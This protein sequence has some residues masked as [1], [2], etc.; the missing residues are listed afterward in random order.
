VFIYQ[1]PEPPRLKRRAVGS[2]NASHNDLI[3][4]EIWQACL[5]PNPKSLERINEIISKPKI[6]FAALKYELISDPGLA[7]YYLKRI[8]HLSESNILPIDPLDY[9]KTISLNELDKLFNISPQQI[10]S[11]K[12]SSSSSGQLLRLQHSF[13]ATKAA[14]NISRQLNVPAGI[15][16]ALSHVSQAAINLL[17]FKYPSQFQRALLNKRRY[18]T[19]IEETLSTLTG[20]NLNTINLKIL[21]L[22]GLPIQ[23]QKEIELSQKNKIFDP[24][25][26][27][28]PITLVGMGDLL[29]RAN[30][31]E[32]FPEAL[33]QWHQIEERMEKLGLE[34]PRNEIE[35]E[36][37][38]F[39]NELGVNS[40]PYKSSLFN[41]EAVEEHSN[42]TKV[43]VNKYVVKLPE[44]LNQDFLQVYRHI[45]KHEF[46]QTALK[47][48]VEKLAP[49]LKIES[50][51]LYLLRS[52]NSVLSA[53]LNFGRIKRKRTNLQ[54]ESADPIAQSLFASSP[55]I[56]DQGDGIVLSCCALQKSNKQG[57]IL[58]EF[59]QTEFE[60]IATFAPNL[61]QALTQTL[62]DIIGQ[63][64]E[65]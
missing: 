21:K 56:Q 16:F 54:I 29:A 19:P 24:T 3:F 65:Q 58:L 49:K 52:D 32:H 28:N 7:L 62:V 42:V 64:S 22:L 45:K 2:S 57:V 34:S 47:N 23:L 59:I 31:I 14:A 27:S 5:P 11:H 39:M 8:S 25:F 36:M 61:I 26:N 12:L 35:K 48:Y 20:I 41:F 30:D 43:S 40:L 17:A 46:S 18:R 63:G 38:S 37:R 13:I 53:A 10:S 4:D 9:I 44:S 50:G 55:F 6:D 60:A 1:A 15:S 33:T 51:C